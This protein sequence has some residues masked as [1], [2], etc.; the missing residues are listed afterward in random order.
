M[1]ES[2]IAFRMEVFLF[3]L[4]ENKSK[5]K[6]MKYSFNISLLSCHL[7]STEI[8]INGMRFVFLYNIGEKAQILMKNLF[9]EKDSYVNHN[10]RYRLYKIKAHFKGHR[11]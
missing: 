1:I 3:D 4:A 6:I 10:Q 8:C 11:R 5:Q 2:E 9:S 7:T